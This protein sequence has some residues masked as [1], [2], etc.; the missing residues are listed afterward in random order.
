MWKEFLSLLTD[1]AFSAKTGLWNA[2]DEYKVYPNPDSSQFSQHSDRD[3]FYTLGQIV[4]KSMFD[5]IL[6]NIQF[7]SFF[8]RKLLKLYNYV[9]DLK[10]LDPEVHK[11]LMWLN[12]YKGDFADLGITWSFQQNGAEVEICAGGSNK[13][14]TKDNVKR[15]ICELSHLRLNKQIRKQS[16]ALR[17]FGFGHGS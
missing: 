17:R 1:E 9:D 16:K 12:S 6:V 10:S 2:T 7:A 14:V 4:G 13:F 5:G 8:L 3:M 11:H 15:Y